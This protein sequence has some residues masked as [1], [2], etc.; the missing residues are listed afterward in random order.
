IERLAGEGAEVLERIDAG[1]DR[2][3]RASVARRV[4]GDLDAPPAR[5]VDDG[6]QLGRRESRELARLAGHWIGVEPVGEDLD[7]GDTVRHLLSHFAA[8]RVRAIDDGAPARHTDAGRE[9]LWQVAAC[10]PYARAAGQDARPLD[11]ALRDRFA[12]R[13]IRVT[14]SFGAHV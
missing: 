13:D 9:P 10:N 3:A 6:V 14:R 11:Q 1:V 7:P 5:L 12:Q 2:V 4:R 8:G